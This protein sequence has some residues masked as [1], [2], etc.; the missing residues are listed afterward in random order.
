VRFVDRRNAAGLSALHVAVARGS[1]STAAALILRGH[2][3]PMCS[4]GFS[5]PR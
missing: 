1:T 2:R 5:A 3:W 4:R